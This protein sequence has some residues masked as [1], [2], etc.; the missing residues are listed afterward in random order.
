MPEILI[1]EGVASSLA[2]VRDR[3]TLAVR[4]LAP[5]DLRLAR[6][7]ARDGVALLPQWLRWQRAEAEHFAGAAP[8]PDDVLVDGAPTL[9]HDADREYVEAGGPLTEG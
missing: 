2:A 5:D 1:V 7:M 9:P 3:L 4:V 6:G 8:G